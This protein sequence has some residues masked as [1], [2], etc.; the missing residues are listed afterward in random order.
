MIRKPAYV[1]VELRTVSTTSP[2]MSADASA[3]FPSAAA[4]MKPGA[5]SDGTSFTSLSITGSIWSERM[6]WEERE[7]RATR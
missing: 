1:G 4:L 6:G 7:Q 2:P 5:L 3:Y